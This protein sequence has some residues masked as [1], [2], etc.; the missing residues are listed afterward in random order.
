MSMHQSGS[1]ISCVMSHQY[2]AILL[3]RDTSS[4][5]ISGSMTAIH[6]VTS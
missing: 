4:A 3:H 2:F 1:T 6:I 5:G